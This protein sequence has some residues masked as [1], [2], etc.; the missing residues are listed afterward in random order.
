MEQA[1]YDVLVRVAEGIEKNTALLEEIKGAMYAEE[2]D[3]EK[4]KVH[5]SLAQYAKEIADAHYSSDGTQSDGAVQ[6]GL[7]TIE[8]LLFE[9]NA[10]LDEMCIRLQ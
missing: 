3:V 2:E 9:I 4:G 1:H 8:N 5:F 10:T 6:A 7:K